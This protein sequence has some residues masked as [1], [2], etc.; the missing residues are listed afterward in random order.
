MA[1]HQREKIQRLDNVRPEWL[2]EDKMFKFIRS[3]FSF[4]MSDVFGLILG[5]CFI[6][7]CSENELFLWVTSPQLYL[8]VLLA[9]L[10]LHSYGWLFIHHGEST[11]IKQMFIHIIRDFLRISFSYVSMIGVYFFIHTFF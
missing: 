2:G 6:S 1:L 3:M 4:R 10:L 11:Y 5:A 8:L 7:Y 9:M